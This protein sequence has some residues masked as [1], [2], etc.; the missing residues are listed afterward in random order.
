M[1]ALAASG[2]LIVLGLQ[3]GVNGELNLGALLAKRAW[4]HA[5][6]LRSRS[7]AQKAAIVAATVDFVW[8]QIEDGRVRPIIDRVLSLDDAAEAHRLMES[9]EHIGK[10]LLRVR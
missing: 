8:P 4:I 3:G 1:R 5:A 6:S 7:L 9:S 2:R 10:V